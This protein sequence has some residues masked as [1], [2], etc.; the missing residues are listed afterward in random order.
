MNIY[1]TI[2]LQNV[3]RLFIIL[4]LFCSPEL[5]FII[6]EVF[7]DAADCANSFSII[8]LFVKKWSICIDNGDSIVIINTKSDGY[9]SENI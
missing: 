2:D 8:L 6:S 5:L 9:Y 7:V 3:Q 1:L 4:D